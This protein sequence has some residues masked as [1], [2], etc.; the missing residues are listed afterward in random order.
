MEM[1][2]TMA[3]NFLCRTLFL[4]RLKIARAG[5]SGKYKEPL[6][7][8]KNIYVLADASNYLQISFVFQK[9]NDC[10]HRPTREIFVS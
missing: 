4:V 10:E 3:G 7:G 1:M 6:Q 2:A 9:L 5:E 8:R